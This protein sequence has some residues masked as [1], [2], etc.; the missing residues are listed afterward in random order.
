MLF[1]VDKINI[2]G[3]FFDKSYEVGIK[4]RKIDISGLN[5]A[6]VVAKLEAAIAASFDAVYLPSFASISGFINLLMISIKKM[7][8][9]SRMRAVIEA[10]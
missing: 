3:V 4:E 8:G 5:R 1:W 10:I 6:K 2:Q 7:D 9:T